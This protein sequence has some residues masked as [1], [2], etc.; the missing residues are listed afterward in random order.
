MNNYTAN[1]RKSQAIFQPYRGRGK[2]RTKVPNR[3]IR[4]HGTGRESL[5]PKA[6]NPAQ[7]DEIRE[8]IMEEATKC[9]LERLLRAGWRTSCEYCM[10]CAGSEDAALIAEYGCPEA[11][12]GGCIEGIM[13]YFE[14]HKDKGA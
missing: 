5:V 3:D 13:E 11:A 10:Y 4:R 2:S 8:K 12:E 14:E 1:Q 7:A 9:A 6:K